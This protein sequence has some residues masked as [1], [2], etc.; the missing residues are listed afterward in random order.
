MSSANVYTAL[1]SY[2]QNNS[3]DLW[4]AANSSPDLAGMLPV[5]G[6]FN[7]N[8]AY[9]LTF[10]VL[11]QSPSGASV[12]LTGSGSFNGANPYTANATLQYI[13]EGNVFSLELAITTDWIISNFFSSLPETLMQ[14]PTIQQGILW[15]PSV[16]NG[17]TIRTAVFSGKT[18]ET[19]LT[20]TGF[21]L[22]PNNPNLLNRTPMVGPWPLRLSGS[23]EMPTSTRSY[24]LINLDARGNDTIINV[25]K[26]QGISGPDAMG[27]S[28]PGLTLLVQPLKPQQ[29]NRIAFSTIELFAD[30]ALGEIKGRIATLVLSNDDV[31]NFTVRF[32]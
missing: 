27:L 32:T 30:F 22:Q 2:I 3:I 13:Q 20:L 4:A 5:L 7:I 29:P 18:R 25:A 16:L 14:V 15:Y 23:V 10:V 11:T 21:L 19:K 6:L 24:P 26:E 1:N 9:T 17:M 28:N 31:W 8:A 12:R